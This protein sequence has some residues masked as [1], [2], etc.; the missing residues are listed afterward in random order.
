MT[1]VA[2]QRKWY[3]DEI[4]KRIRDEGARRVGLSGTEALPL[5]EPGRLSDDGR[6]WAAGRIAADAGVVRQ[7]IRR[8]AQARASAAR[9][10]R[11][12]IPAGSAAVAAVAGVCRGVAG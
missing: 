2:R 8:E 3:S 4:H 5:V 1:T 10:A 12:R 11:P 9:P 7:T 6:L